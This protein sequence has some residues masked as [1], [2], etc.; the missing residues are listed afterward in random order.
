MNKLGKVDSHLKKTKNKKKTYQAK[1]Y[2]N[3]QEKTNKQ[4][5]KTEQKQKHLLVH[6]RLI[7]KNKNMIN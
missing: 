2:K 1:T 4:T 7:V 5:S 6:T 3:N